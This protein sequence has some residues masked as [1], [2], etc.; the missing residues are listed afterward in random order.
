MIK[1]NSDSRNVLAL[2]CDTFLKFNCTGFPHSYNFT[3][4]V[5]MYDTV[6]NLEFTEKCNSWFYLRTERNKSL[7]QKTRLKTILFAQ[8]MANPAGFYI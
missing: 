8:L 1:F 2:L 5:L 4:Y 7:Q 6:Q 3:V